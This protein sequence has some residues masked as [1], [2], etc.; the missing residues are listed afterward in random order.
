MCIVSVGDGIAI[1]ER[2]GVRE[3]I[4]VMLL[5]APAVGSWILVFQGSAVRG[6]SAEEAR[7]TESALQAL[8]AA[9]AG[10]TDFERFFADLVDREPELP[11]H[12]KG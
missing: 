11:A 2:R 6:M 1:A 3:R 8:E 12:L 10:E 4:D 5:D 7:A 9:L